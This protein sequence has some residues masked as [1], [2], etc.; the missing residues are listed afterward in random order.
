MSLLSIFV[1]YP[2]NHLRRLMTS[3]KLI[4]SETLLDSLLPSSKKYWL[5]NIGYNLSV[6][7]C[8]FCVCTVVNGTGSNICINVV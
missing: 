5:K 7:F 2:A 6:V 4:S 1:S 3:P 8:S